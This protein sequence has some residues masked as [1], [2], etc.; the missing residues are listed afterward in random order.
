MF[1]DLVSGEIW[2]GC[3]VVPMYDLPVELSNLIKAL[4]DGV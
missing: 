1:L 2:E 4:Y 3:Q